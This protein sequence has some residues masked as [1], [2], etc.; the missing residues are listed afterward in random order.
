MSDKLK[1]MDFKLK[2]IKYQLRHENET[3]ASYKADINA[4]NSKI[5]EL[6]MGQV[7]LQ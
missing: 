1:M 7:H 5:Q 2:K 6:T 4:L 3:S